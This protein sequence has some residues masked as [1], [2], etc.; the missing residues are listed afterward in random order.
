MFVVIWYIFPV[1]VFLTKKNLQP[2]VEPEVLQE[3]A[4]ADEDLQLGEASAEAHP[5]PD[6]ERP[7]VDFMKQFRTVFPDETFTHR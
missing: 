5:R 2:W 7:G 4:D 6:P 1:L 3:L